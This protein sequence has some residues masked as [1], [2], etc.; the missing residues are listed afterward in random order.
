MKEITMYEADDGTIYKTES[1]ALKN[2]IIVSE[3]KEVM[4]Y[5]PSE[6][7]ENYYYYE[8]RNGRVYVQC[9]SIRVLTAKQLFTELYSRYH[10]KIN[11]FSQVNGCLLDNINTLLY[12]VWNQLTCIDSQSRWWGQ[13][14]Y[15]IHGNPKATE[16]KPLTDKI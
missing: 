2:D 7:E 8:W 1:E 9:E 16:Y 14:Y 12:G 10:H 4:S 11:N 3:L 15:A 6:P 5:L 13:N